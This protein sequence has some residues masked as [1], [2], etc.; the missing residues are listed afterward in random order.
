MICGAYVGRQIR[1]TR[2]AESPVTPPDAV[3]LLLVCPHSWI[4]RMVFLYL[5]NSKS[6][7]YTEQLFFENEKVTFYHGAKMIRN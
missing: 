7:S 2:S 4:I 5:I 1:V 3:T 6:L